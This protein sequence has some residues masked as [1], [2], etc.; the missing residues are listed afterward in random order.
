[1]P[2]LMSTSL[3]NLAT[4]AEVPLVGP[5]VALRVISSSAA[6]RLKHAVCSRTEFSKPNKMRLGNL[7]RVALLESVASSRWQRRNEKELLLAVLV[8]QTPH[9]PPPACSL[10]ACLTKHLQTSSARWKN[11]RRSAACQHLQAA[12]SAEMRRLFGHGCFVAW[13]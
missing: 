10:R 13:A 3:G 9:P 12:A 11:H 7:R 4:W 6:T 8:A 1:M 5:A 2:C